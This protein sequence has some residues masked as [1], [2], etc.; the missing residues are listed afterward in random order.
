MMGSVRSWRLILM[1][2][3]LGL[4][5]ALIALTQ[6]MNTRSPRTPNTSD[7]TASSTSPQSLP[8][9]PHY[10]LQ[11]QDRL[12]VF[13]QLAAVYLRPW[14]PLP[15]QPPTA[16]TTRMLDTMES[17][18]RGAAFRIRIVNGTLLYRHTVWWTQ[19]YRL[20]R[21]NW[22]LSFL[23]QLI[24][25]GRLTANLDAVLS[26]SDAP[27]VGSDSTSQGKE[28]SAGFPLFTMR[29]SVSLI[30][31]PL[32]DS[33]VFGSNGRYVWDEEAKQVEWDSKRAVAVF[34]GSASCFLM[35]ADNW[36][37]CPRVKAAQLAK[38]HLEQLDVGI[39]KWN[40]ISKL[41]LV[42]PPPTEEE[43]EASTNLT[44]S[45][46]LSFL[47]QAH[48][49]YIID[50]DGGVG[51]S[52]QAVSA[53]N[54]TS[55]NQTISTYQHCTHTVLQQRVLTVRTCLAF[56]VWC[57]GRVYCPPALCWCLSSLQRMRT[58]SL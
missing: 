5:V 25:T 12:A 18:Y 11:E 22:W 10:D 36:H 39:T 50:M 14:T 26:M 24:D 8:F 55:S 9:H 27:R 49:K 54:H 57:C 43:V 31:I 6:L 33:V 23:R 37:A 20:E 13:D 35:H 32:V 52:R 47:E 7:A 58:G 3:A 21:M 44:L 2:L 15:G 38:Q 30:D 29:T 1:T 48:Y 28:G 42:H 51:S 40:Q 45:Q 46:P 19:T 34:R 4:A 56:C 41:S 53:H 17:M 16:I